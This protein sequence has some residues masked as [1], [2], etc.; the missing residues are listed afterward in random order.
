MS[1]LQTPPELGHQ[2]HDD[3][4]L[5]SHLAR[6]LP[7]DMRRE[8]LPSLEALGGLAG[9]PL[10][11]MQEEDRLHEPRLVQWDPWGHRVDRIELTAVWKEAR[12]LSCEYGLVAVPYERRHAEHSRVHQAALIHLFAPA[13]DI[14]SCPLA[15]SDGAAKTLL[16]H[17]ATALAERAIPRL[18][19]RDP[20][21]VWTSGQWMT[22]QIGG[23]DVGLSE[24]R[25]LAAGAKF[26]LFGTKFFTSAATSEMALTL[27][28]PEG[29][30]PGGKGL[31]LYYLEVFDDAGK[32]NGISVERLKEKLG[33][34]KLPTAELTLDGTLATP[35]CGTSGGVRAITPMLNITRLWN[36]LCAVSTM[37]RCLALARDYARRR[38]AFGATLSQ[39]PLHADTLA[40][41]QAEYE[42]GFHL[43]WLA[44]ELIGKEEAKVATADE[45][46]LLRLLTPLAKL[47]TGKQGVAVAS[48]ALEA[49]G[50]A[51]YMED[52][53]LPVLLR[54]AQV[55]AIWEGTTN[56]LSLDVI[57]ALVKDGSGPALAA[58]AARLAGEAKD[59]ALVAAGRTATAGMAHA[60]SWLVETGGT[61]PVAVEAG[62]RRVAL[63]LGRSLAL[64]ALVR[65]AQWSLTHEEDGRARAAAIR[66]A[67]HG[68]DVLSQGGPDAGA[69]A[70]DEA[71]PV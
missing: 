4:V 63:T 17:G 1:F 22:E 41:M 49:F 26:K 20:S 23:S 5:M 36:S 32:Y 10:F 50:G 54:D 29:N 64:A 43:A 40:G 27:A 34:R 55:M 9:G 56:V 2:L 65:H 6:V 19:S 8:V 46:A 35:V 18:T 38:V 11:R 21:R 31:A 51:G 37:R 59:A 60:L 44:V 30:G 14:Y 16:S 53:M 33:T 62:A 67:S 48:E 68:V 47:T 58:L 3:R 42:A 15:M 25:A 69:L 57:R 45:L 70:R 52:T 28:R 39:K 61:D 66:F 7:E 71:I 13:T 12:R 24:T